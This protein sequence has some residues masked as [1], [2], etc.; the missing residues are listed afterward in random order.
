MKRLLVLCA[1]LTSAS[2]AQ[3]SSSIV[4]KTD[5]P[6]KIVSILSK[7]S[8]MLAEVNLHNSTDRNVAQVRL[9]LL[10]AVPP[11]CG[12]RPYLSEDYTRDYHVTVSSNAD[13]KLSDVG[14]SPGPVLKLKQLKEASTVISQV[15]VLS[16]TFSDG[17]EWKLTRTDRS[18][19]DLLMSE[20]TAA[21]CPSSG[22]TMRIKDGKRCAQ[23]STKLTHQG[24]DGGYYKC[25]DGAKQFCTNQ[26]EASCLNTA[27]TSKNACANQACQFIPGGGGAPVQDTVHPILPDGSG[28]PTLSLLPDS[29]ILR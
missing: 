16:V 12:A 1:C 25:V 3:T 6:V 11:A 27:C 22:S 19:D 18:F 20:T 7:P 4:N 15:T 17:S 26:G 28:A 23:A 8:D 5:S 10:L 21:M 24:F 14:M 29:V 13:F 2:F 9:G